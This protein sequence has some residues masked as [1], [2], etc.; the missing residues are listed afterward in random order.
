M[1]R[2]SGSRLPKRKEEFTYR[3]LKTEELNKLSTD[4]F[5]ELLPSRQRR[6]LKRGLTKDHKR[7]LSRVKDREV[8][9]THLRDMII[10]P[11]MVG[12]TIEIYNGKAFNRVEIMPEMVGHYLGEYSLTRARVTHGS[13]GVGATRS[14]KFVPLK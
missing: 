12:K 8:V 9:R 13:A 14:S 6:R 4:E 2:K 10:L 5:M 3:G 7:L 11:E 1:A